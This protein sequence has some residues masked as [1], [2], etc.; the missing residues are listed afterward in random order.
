QRIRQN[1]DEDIPPQTEDLINE[2]VYMQMVDDQLRQ[3]EMDR[4][5]LVVTPSEIRDMV[6]GPNPHPAIA[7]YFRGAD[8]QIDRELLNSFAQNQANTE[9]WVGVEQYLE[10]ERRRE[11]LDNLLA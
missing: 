4:L 6:F 10:A 2:Q 3:Q 9:W 7:D 1:S 5:G 8:G 11:K